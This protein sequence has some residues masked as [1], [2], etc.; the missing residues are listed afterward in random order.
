MIDVYA[1]T[2]VLAKLY[3]SEPNSSAAESLV[4]PF[5]PPLPLIQLHM[6]ELRNALR[7]KVFRKEITLSQLR[8]SLADVETDMAER[9]L[10]RMP[11]DWDEVY[12]A[13]EKQSSRWAME[14]GCRSLDA[15]HVGAACVLRCHTI[16]TFDERQARL[17]EKAGLVVKGC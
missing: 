16:L 5:D 4:R 14:I 12:E 17:A 15:L 8:Q 11:I 3:V 2:S 1:D 7:L 6:L 9:R 13:A 10:K